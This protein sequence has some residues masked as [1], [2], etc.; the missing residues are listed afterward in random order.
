MADVLRARMSKLEPRIHAS[1]QCHALEC[2]QLAV[3]G[4]VCPGCYEKL[5][6]P[7]KNRINVARANEDEA[8]MLAARREGATWFRGQR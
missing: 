7:I 3:G 4:L 6:D 2:G 5:P 1:A 8:K